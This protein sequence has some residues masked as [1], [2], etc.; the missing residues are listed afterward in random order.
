MTARA[1]AKK[2][3]HAPAS[4]IAPRR[5]PFPA[6]IQ[7]LRGPDRRLHPIKPRCQPRFSSSATIGSRV[8]GSKSRDA[9]PVSRCR[10]RSGVVSPKQAEGTLEQHQHEL[11]A[12]IRNLAEQMD[13]AY[14]Q[15]DR[16]GNRAKW[17]R[18]I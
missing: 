12:H 18:E 16:P 5:P 15:A 17:N 10:Q 2:N 4:H 11:M 8:P 13:L 1:T 3:P 9:G 6:R 7:R 14:D